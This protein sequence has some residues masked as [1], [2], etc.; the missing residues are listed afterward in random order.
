MIEPGAEKVVRLHAKS[1]LVNAIPAH[2]GYSRER[3]FEDKI[4]RGEAFLRTINLV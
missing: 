2:L 1:E 4:T 3:R